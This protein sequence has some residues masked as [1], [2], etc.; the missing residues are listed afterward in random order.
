L[1]GNNKKQAG[2]ARREEYNIAGKKIAGIAGKT[3]RREENRRDR[4]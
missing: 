4:N 1:Q 2:G 3:R